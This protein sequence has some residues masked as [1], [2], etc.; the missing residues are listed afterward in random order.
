MGP[1]VGG[2]LAEPVKRFPSTFS[3]GS[4]WERHPFFLPNLVVAAIFIITSFVGLFLLMETNPR[5]SR[6]FDKGRRVSS[7]LRK[8]LSRW[9]GM[10]SVSNDT[11]YSLVDEDDGYLPMSQTPLASTVEER[12]DEIELN[13]GGKTASANPQA[14][15]AD[16]T[17][18][19]F[20]LQV[21]LQILSVSL[22]AFHKVASDTLIPVFLAFPRSEG[23]VSHVE[24]TSLFRLTGSFGLSPS[25]VGNVLLTQAV[26]AVLVQII[27]VPRLLTRF[28]PI[29]TYRW[30]LFVFPWLY[31]MTPFV[32]K[33]P[34]PLSL[35]ALLV[36]LWIKVLLVALGYVCSAILCVHSSYPE[37]L[38][39]TAN[40]R[41]AVLT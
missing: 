22:L 20:T 23:S 6:G 7:V 10:G 26:T 1:A 25:S 35:I 13:I 38:Q 30:T 16:P 8:I 40:P 21:I 34:S 12:N 14:D 15:H 9:I 27:I 29:Q 41:L 33:L 19:T 31:C 32:V 5:F 11:N 37:S 36:D 2:L 3:P 39:I 24:H 17:R 4:F 28:G 18:K